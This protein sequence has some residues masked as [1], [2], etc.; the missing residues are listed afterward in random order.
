[1][2][3]VKND[4]MNIKI[5]RNQTKEQNQIINNNLI[6]ERAKS[7]SLDSRSNLNLKITQETYQFRDDTNKATNYNEKMTDDFE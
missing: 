5:K 2:R 1:M 4:K 7:S 6:F 3:V